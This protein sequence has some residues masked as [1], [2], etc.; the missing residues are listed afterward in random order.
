M[1][2]SCSKD[3]SVDFDVKRNNIVGDW[4]VTQATQEIIDRHKLS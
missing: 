1:F 3:D 4:E 2:L